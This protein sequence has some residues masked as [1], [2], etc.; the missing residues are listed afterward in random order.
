LAA[1]KDRS[2]DPSHVLLITIDTLRV[3]HLSCY[4]YD[5]NTSPNIDKLASEGVRFERAY[6][7]IPLTG[8]AHLSLLTSR[9]P[10][11]HGATNNG[12][13]V[14]GEAKV[15]FL[16]QI[17]RK[18]GYHAGAFISAWPLTGRLTHL[19]RWFD[20]YD[21][22]LTRR[23]KLFNSS[24]YAEDVTPLVVR[25][26]ERNAHRHFFLW[27]HYFDP[28]SPYEQR[29]GFAPR[30]NGAQAP[31]YAAQDADMRDRIAR[32]DSE[33]AYTDAH[34]G[35]L[36]GT[37]DRLNLRNSTLV[38]LAAD[39]GESL[40][41]HGYVGHG[42][43]L[44]ED[45]VHV[46]LIF[47]LP[48][49]VAPGK[50]IPQRVSLLDVAPTVVD[51]TGRP[52]KADLHKAFAGRS[53]AAV[54][55]S[56]GTLA[57]RSIRYLTFGGEKLFF[58]RWLSWLWMPNSEL[59]SRIGREDGNR[60]LIWSPEEESLAIFDTAQ[61]PWEIKPRVVGAENAAYKS[62]TVLLARWF[63]ATD[64]ASGTAVLSKRDVEVLRSLGYLQ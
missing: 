24:R 60:K 43:H 10:Q 28:H 23:Y 46:P 42:R 1:P 37:L 30:A 52:A 44:Y 49:V 21:E 25:W 40:G 6:T 33:I 54:L 20:D 29:N 32:Y 55:T 48:G 50:T 5:R 57:P 38:V 8:P 11:E 35:I 14:A 59:P 17:F 39:H 27:V 64:T 13:A 53:L 45:I 47:R 15:V 61:D 3:D 9:Y 62:E 16:P 18:H 58:P 26:L 4:G 63:K 31:A 51:L 56:G 34:V 19:N 36:L 22:T 41:E 7:T 12:V 2:K